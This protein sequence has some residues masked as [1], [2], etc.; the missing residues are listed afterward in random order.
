MQHNDPKYLRLF[1]CLHRRQL[2]QLLFNSPTHAPLRPRL[3]PSPRPAAFGR[4]WT[5]SLASGMC[6]S[7][8]RAPC[9]LWACSRSSPRP[10]RQTAATNSGDGREP[11]R[12]RLECPCF[13]SH[14]NGLSISNLSGLAV[15]AFRF[16]WTL[17]CQRPST[18]AFFFFL[19]FFPFSPSPVARRPPCMLSL[20]CLCFEGP[21]ETTRFPCSRMVSSRTSSRV[22]D[23]TRAEPARSC[24]LSWSTTSRRQQPSLTRPSVFVCS[25]RE[26]PGR[27]P[28]LSV[29]GL[30]FSPGT[31][32]RPLVP[33]WSFFG[34]PFACRH[35]PSLANARMRSSRPVVRWTTFA[36]P[37]DRQRPGQPSGPG[38]TWPGLSSIDSAGPAVQASL[39]VQLCFA[40][41]SST[42]TTGEPI[43]ASAFRC[44]VGRHSFFPD[45]VLFRC[46]CSW[47]PTRTSVCPFPFISQPSLEMSS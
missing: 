9:R 16:A 36:C 15:S 33:G 14:S 39:L 30:Q 28:C 23:W 46:P 27:S 13:V 26:E 43:E 21:G 18:V 5:S 34:R 42:E 19:S 40:R 3:R 20:P 45:L 22:G 17:R 6:A 29:C 41:P 24:S 4:R 12:Q 2:L 31:H 1:F 47:A 8:V 25:D 7:A 11:L 37:D 38:L 10:A 44:P 32:E 35:P